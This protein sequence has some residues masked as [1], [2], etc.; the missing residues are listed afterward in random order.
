MPLR[1]SSLP[2]LVLGYL[3]LL[4]LERRETDPRSLR[5]MASCY[6]SIPLDWLIAIVSCS[7]KGWSVR[8]PLSFTG[9]PELSLFLRLRGVYSVFLCIL[10]SVTYST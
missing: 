9:P 2:A 3:G 7:G 8:C 10:I 4:L 5:Y 1:R 6:F